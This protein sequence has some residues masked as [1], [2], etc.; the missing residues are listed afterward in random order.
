MAV[1]GGP[2]SICLLHCLLKLRDELDTVFIAAHLDH[3]VRESSREDAEFVRGAA[4]DAGIECVCGRIGEDVPAPAGGGSPEEVLRR[5]RYAFLEKVAADSGAGRIAVGHNMDDQAETLLLRMMRGT[6]ARGLAGMR[7]VRG[8]VVRPLLFSSREQILRFCESMNLEYRID[9]SNAD[10]N[11]DRNRVRH[12][13]IPFLEREFNPRISERL[14]NLAVLIGEDVDFLD[15][16]TGAAFSLLRVERTETRVSFNIDA[17]R[18]L[19]P[20]LLKRML[21]RAVHEIAGEDSS[22][23]ESSHI[24]DIASLVNENAAGRSVHIPGVVVTA[25][26]KTLDFESTRGRSH[27]C[28]PD[29]NAKADDAGYFPLPVSTAP[30]RV[31]IEPLCLELEFEEL[32]PY[33]DMQQN[34]NPLT[35][36]FDADSLRGAIELRPPQAGDRFRPLG[37]EDEKKLSDFFIDEKVDR[38]MREKTVLLTCGGEIAWVVGMRIDHRFR[39]LPGRTKKVLKI[40]AG[41]FR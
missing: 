39:I 41:Y 13:L 5:A 38:D 6:S 27:G 7:P 1:S 31:R 21:L 9:E 40:T 8:S 4:S 16:L 37:M 20:V 11:Y 24:L 34:S 30:G 17:S 33:E 18:R 28:A 29:D 23:V 26:Y 12:S 10:C 35:A 32:A 22:R 2:D 15:E 36:F 25:R 3:A 14:S 19:P